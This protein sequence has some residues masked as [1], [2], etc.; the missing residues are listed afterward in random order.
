MLSS[1]IG[2]LHFLYKAMGFVGFVTAFFH[3]RAQYNRGKNDAITEINQAN[4]GSFKDEAN[5]IIND[6]PGIGTAAMDKLLHTDIH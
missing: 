6:A 4:I 3:G 2:L 5:K 1:L